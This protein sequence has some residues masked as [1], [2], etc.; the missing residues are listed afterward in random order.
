MTSWIIFFC[1]VSSGISAVLLF[2]QKR[3]HVLMKD[4]MT[5]LHTV[6]LTEILYPLMHD[7][8][9]PVLPLGMT[10]PPFGDVKGVSVGTVHPEQM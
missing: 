2:S 9:L 10:E 8:P 6:N 1:F 4:E 3:F 5:Y 7:V